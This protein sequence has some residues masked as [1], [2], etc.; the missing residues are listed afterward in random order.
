MLHEMD[1]ESNPIKT[2]RNLRGMQ[3]G[4]IVMNKA[5]IACHKLFGINL[6]ERKKKHFT[7]SNRCLL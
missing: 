5:S 7:S 2:Q 3:K 4:R 1:I 6:K